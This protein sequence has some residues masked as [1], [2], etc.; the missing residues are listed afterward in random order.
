MKERKEREKRPTTQLLN[1]WISTRVPAISTWKTW[2]SSFPELASFPAKFY[3][4]QESLC[5][6]P[7]TFSN[8]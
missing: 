5:F 6:P 3:T 2:C 4:E 8:N 1:L 7:I